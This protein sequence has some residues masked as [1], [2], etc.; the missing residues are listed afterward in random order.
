VIAP[1][2]GHRDDVGHV[3]GFLV[4]DGGHCQR[5]ISPGTLSE[6]ALVFYADLGRIGPPY[7]DDVSADAERR[8]LARAELRRRNAM[9]VP[10]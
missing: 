6:R 1:G 4:A 3:R 10:R 5:H 2:W 9:T 7:A 8:V